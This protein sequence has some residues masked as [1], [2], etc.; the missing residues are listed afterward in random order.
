MTR[1]ELENTTP[2]VVIAG[3]TGTGKSRLA[4]DLALRIDGEIVNYDS[5]QL[6]RG[7]DLGSAKPAARDRDLVPH[8]L[9][10]VVDP[11]DELNAAE[12]ARRA[13]ACCL[14]I[15]AR[16]KV[17][18]LVGGTGFY[19][20]ALLAGLPEMPERDEEF[21][22]RFRSLW[23]RPRGRV[24]LRA[25]LERVDPAA[26]AKVTPRDR[27]RTE[28]ALE[29]WRATGRPISAREA[30]K[31][32]APERWRNVKFALNAP[33]PVL[34]D[35]LDRRVDRMYDAGLVDETRGLLERGPE[36][37]RTFDAIGYREAVRFIH[38]E[39]ALPDAIAETKR[40]TR[41]Y[42]KRQITWLRSQPDLHWLD[43]RE[44]IATA[45]STVV[46]RVESKPSA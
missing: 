38:G 41:L 37:A 18:I 44:G 11:G 9:I 8:H 1:A 36:D 7:F 22:R 31:A 25:W 34:V 23:S 35:W 20:R 13:E 15:L 26:A 17:P 39:I 6:V 33:R 28:R 19:L 32:T 4:I 12:F 43:V 14:E 24:H 5:V 21:R 40:R 10:D 42:A 16:E 3:P 29:V 45:L 30:P 2:L 46:E 27:H